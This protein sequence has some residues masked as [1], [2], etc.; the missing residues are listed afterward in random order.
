MRLWYGKEDVNMLLNVGR[1]MVD[2]LFGVVYKEYEGRSYFI[3]WENIEE[4]LI[5]MWRDV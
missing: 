3:M 1:Y 2:R 5:D 4:I